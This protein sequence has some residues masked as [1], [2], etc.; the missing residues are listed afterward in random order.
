VF[1][2]IAGAM[3]LPTGELV[4]RVIAAEVE[5]TGTLPRDARP[6]GWEGT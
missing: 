1:D 4:R 3:R 6:L 2:D 5:A